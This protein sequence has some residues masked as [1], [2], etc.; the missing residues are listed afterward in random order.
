V[1]YFVAISL[2]AILVALIPFVRPEWMPKKN[3]NTAPKYLITV[4]DGGWNTT[5]LVEKYSHLGSYQ[6]GALTFEY[7]GKTVEIR[8][9]VVTIERVENAPKS[10]KN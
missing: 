5:F 9:G 10:T 3:A 4:F 6:G 2:A 1:K 8:S 7:K